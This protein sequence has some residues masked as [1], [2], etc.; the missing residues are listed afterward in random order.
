MLF[1]KMIELAALSMLQKW[2][3]PHIKNS[4]EGISP[5]HLNNE[6]LKHIAIKI[7]SLGIL[8]F[9]NSLLFTAGVIVMVVAAAHSIDVYNQFQLTSVFLAG[10]IIMATGLVLGGL[11][12]W[13]LLSIKITRTDIIRSPDSETISIS[14]G[15]VLPLIEG[16][17]EGLRRPREYRR[18]AGAIGRLPSPMLQE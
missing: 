4:G 14:G 7:S 9:L 17:L 6:Q 1:K 16:V 5:I 15:V 10:L 2:L 3:G 8:I 13:A 11:T 18:S 12:A